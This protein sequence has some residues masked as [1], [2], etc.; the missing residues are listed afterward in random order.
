MCRRPRAIYFRLMHR[1]R[2][3][4]YFKH[5]IEADVVHNGIC[6]L[7]TYFNVMATNESIRNKHYTMMLFLC[8]FD[9]ILKLGSLRL[10]GADAITLVSYQWCSGIS[11][12]GF[13]MHG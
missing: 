11:I 9:S 5:R 12:L 4:D 13:I 3:S 2:Y 1:A 8:L 6:V 10:F 7:P